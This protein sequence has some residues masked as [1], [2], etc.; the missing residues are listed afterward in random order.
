MSM[1]RMDL[2]LMSASSAVILLT[3]VFAAALSTP[4]YTMAPRMKR[5]TTTSTN[6]SGYAVPA[7]TG[8][9]TDVKGSWIVPTVQ[10][11]T[12]SGSY[13][14]FWVGID[15][16]GSSSVEQ[17]GTDSDMTSSGASYYAWFEFY[18]HPAYLVPITVRA[19][20]VIS[21]EVSYSS[22]SFTVTIKDGTQTWSTSSKVNQAHRSS[23]EWIVEAPYSGGVL[24]LADFG[25]VDFGHQYT[26]VPSTCYATISGIT[27][28][29]GSFKY[30]PIT[31]VTS[32]GTVKASPSQL[33]SGGDSF[34]IT[35]ESAGP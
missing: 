7:S 31:M 32:S 29:I 25:T 18:P 8:S 27:G 33:S 1:G 11:G 16:Y 24:P 20:D 19:G 22:R 14:S 23:A 13:S 12:P 15:G 35:W 10:A 9:V 5:D 4:V 34:T 6:W 26:N 2:K 3:I 30:V 17:I 28:D 21:A